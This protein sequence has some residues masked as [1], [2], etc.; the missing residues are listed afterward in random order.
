MRSNMRTHNIHWLR[1]RSSRRTVMGRAGLAAL[2]LGGAALTACASKRG[3]GA[4]TTGSAS[5]A[6]AT[7]QKGGT[8]TFFLPNNPATL[9][10]QRVTGHQT[11]M[12]VGA[13][14]SRLFRAKLGPTTDD[15]LKHEIENDLAISAESPDA[16]TWT[17]K[18]RPDAKFHNV[19]PVNGHPV[20]A[21]DIKATFTRALDPAINDPSR[22]L[23][24]M[25]DL[26]QI[27][28]PAKDT[29][30]FKLKYPYGPFPTLLA[31]PLYAWVYP[32]EALTNGYDPAK[33]IIGSGP[34]LFDSYTPDIGINLKRNPD[35]FEKDRPYID[36]VRIAIIPDSAQQIAQLGAG[37]L[38]I[39]NQ[40]QQKADLEAATKVSPKAKS[41]T[42]PSTSVGGTYYFQL[43]DPRSPWQDIRL[44]QAVSMAV[45][46][47]T[48]GKVI[49]ENQYVTAFS[50]PPSQG[51]WSLTS[52]QLDQATAPY[53]KFNLA[54]AKKLYAAAGA[55]DYRWK[56]VYITG[57]GGTE[58]DSRMSETIHNML[59]AL[60]PNVT[61]ATQDY[62][63]DFVN[64]GKGSR[65]GNFPSDEVIEGGTAPS[66]ADVD[67]VLFGYWHS[68]STS[69]ES[70]VKDPKLDGLIDKARSTVKEAD[71]RQAYLDV[72]KYIA[73]QVYS[74]GGFPVGS[75]Y[76]LVAPRV[77]NF[78]VALEDGNDGETWSQVWLAQR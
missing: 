51:A 1:S 50:V 62:Q 32:R 10:P 52:N 69:N 72:Q 2:G 5:D 78:S 35:W 14:M 22:G 44:R 38:D 57:F 76:M 70:R 67:G 36:G 6:N 4:Q 63:R 34:F 46:R 17:I 43:G 24:N 40:L 59:G 61:L 26:S 71:Q 21:E 48:L 8:L 33:Q 66:I 47:D 75:Y 37:Q 60:T 41:F 73:A 20:E 39:V 54:E 28:M 42:I 58:L 9:D 45:D 77:H 64:S 11:M 68:K 55:T 19:A 23:L 18:L 7:P 27:Q 15:A 25:V 3:T 65:Y 74:F 53:Y 12:P 16:V 56:L 49:F 31:T 13:V 29:I 30:T